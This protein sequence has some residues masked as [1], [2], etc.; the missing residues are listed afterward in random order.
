MYNYTQDSC[1]PIWVTIG[2]VGNIEGPLRNFVDGGW[3]GGVATKPTA[4][5]HMY[6]V[7]SKEETR[8]ERSRGKGKEQEGG[9]E[10][11]G[12]EQSGLQSENEPGTSNATPGRG[13]KGKPASL[14]WGCVPG[15]LG[16]APPLIRSAS[17]LGSVL[18]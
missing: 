15:G 6:S 12:R 17:L 10:T 2:D 1:A 14:R 18:L 3:V 9:K 7:A 4:A 5:E 11:E 13:P 8:K 16:G